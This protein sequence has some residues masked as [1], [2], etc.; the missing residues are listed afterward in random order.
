MENIIK[1]LKNLFR[2]DVEA[3]ISDFSLITDKLGTLGEELLTEAVQ[4]QTASQ[5]KMAQA[6]KA[7]KVAGNFKTL[8]S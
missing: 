6:A 8:I 7:A 2:K 4:L 3:L 5:V 1:Y